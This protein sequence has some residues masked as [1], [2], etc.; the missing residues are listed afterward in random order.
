M[1]IRL[2]AKNGLGGSV[3][4]RASVGAALPRRPLFP[5]NAPRLMKTHTPVVSQPDQ[6]AP[7]IKRQAPE[8]A[9]G[10]D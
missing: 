4:K 3:A 10:N 6:C 9:A 2:L 5:S 8:Q 7:N 1:L